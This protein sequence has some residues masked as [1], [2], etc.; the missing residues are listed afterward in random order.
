VACSTP[1]N[2][3]GPDQH[4]PLDRLT[5][6]QEKNKLNNKQASKKK[7]YIAKR[8][9][10]HE[11]CRVGEEHLPTQTLNKKKKRLQLQKAGRAVNW[12]KQ[13]GHAPRRTLNKQSLQQ[14]MADSR[15]QVTAASDRHSQSCLQTPIFFFSLLLM[16]QRQN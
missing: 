7:R 11:L 10:H 5:P 2:N 6:T 16:R 4:N 1:T 13:K 12:R 14:Q 9:G 8:V 15:R 3:P